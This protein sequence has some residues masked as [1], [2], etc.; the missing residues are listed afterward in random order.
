MLNNHFI[1]NFVFNLYL[2]FF[3]ANSLFFYILQIPKANARA[4]W[5]KTVFL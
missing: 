5:F 2:T 1:E 3:F 4:G